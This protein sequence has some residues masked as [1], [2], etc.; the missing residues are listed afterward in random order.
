MPA[1]LDYT[2][3][4]A[5]VMTVGETAWHREGTNVPRG[6]PAERDLDLAL[7]I[8]GLDFEVEKVPHAAMI[9]HKKYVPVSAGI[10]AVTTDVE[11]VVSE[12]AW[13][14]LRTDIKKVVGTVGGQWHPLQ[15][16][17]AFAPIRPALDEG[18]ARIETAGS[19]RDGKHVW[20]MVAF[21]KE[22]IVERVYADE[23]TRA[24]VFKVEELLNE[25]LPYGLFMNDH[26]GQGKA[27]VKKTGIRVVCANTLDWS[28]KSEDGF[29]IAV[30]H[31]QNVEES[32]RIASEMLFKHIAV[33]I[34]KLATYRETFRET[35]LPERGF[36]RF[37][38][39]KAVPV[40]Q[41]E[42]RI[43]RREGNKRTETALAKAGEK[44]LE[45]RRLWEDGDG[46]V[47]DH[48]AWEAWNGLIQWL[49]H[50]DQAGFRGSRI[51]ALLKGELGR[52]KRGTFGRLLSYASADREDRALMLN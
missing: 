45:I 47:G 28:L 42:N 1:E 26:S 30:R 34:A 2:K 38:L 51:N 44:R 46:H 13:S 17:K 32:Y 43:M 21:D 23:D 4:F 12:D 14:V 3:G 7:Q 39:D 49:D 22:A 16:V 41:L 19:L 50:S 27:V 11:Y 18:I 24:A 29:S 52:V 35:I 33:E 5:A 8:S 10:D 25:I 37:V 6:H 40:A 36:K 20:M 31:T 48:S 9:E 15:N